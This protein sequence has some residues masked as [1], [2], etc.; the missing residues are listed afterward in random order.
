MEGYFKSANGK[1]NIHYIVWEVENP[2]AVVQ[3]VH[4]MSEHIARYDDFAKFLNK[5]GYLVIGHDHLGHGLSV[6]SKEDLGY[7]GEGDTVQYLIQDI[8]KVNEMTQNYKVP[9]YILGHSM[10]SFLAR[11]YIHKYKVDRAIIMGTGHFTK[12]Q[13]KSLIRL[14]KLIARFKGQRYRAKILGYFT[15]GRLAKKIVGGKF[16]WIS[17]SA[18]NVKD[19]IADPLSGFDFTANGYITLGGILFKMASLESKRSKFKDTP[20]LF[21]SG[22]DD[23]L[24][25]GGYGVKKVLE[26]YRKRSW[27]D[28]DMVL[29]KDLRHEVL[30]EDDKRSYDICYEFFEKKPYKI[31]EAQEI[32]EP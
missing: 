13:G 27:K 9:H 18:R 16:D 17:K 7:F 20:C 25:L 10:G 22:G 2:L 29:V 31:L 32:E 24:G 5:K 3:I 23:P 4:G 12:F 11:I 6:E 26:D 8:K 28:T 19:F 30:N 14:A 21:I 1:N 15:T